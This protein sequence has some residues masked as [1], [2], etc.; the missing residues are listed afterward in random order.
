MR[1][2]KEKGKKKI[3]QGYTDFTEFFMSNIMEENK[4]ESIDAL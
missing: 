1:L 3:D 4:L 2:A